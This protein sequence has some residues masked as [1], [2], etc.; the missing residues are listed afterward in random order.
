MQLTADVVWRFARPERDFFRL[1]S[2]PGE[3]RD[4]A[5]PLGLGHTG[6]CFLL[7]SLL[8]ALAAAAAAAERGVARRRRRGG[9]S[10]AM[11]VE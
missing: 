8:L 3:E 6:P 5:E 10:N 4:V 11:I 9:R 2:V 1:E 7:G